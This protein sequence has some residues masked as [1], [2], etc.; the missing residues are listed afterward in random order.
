MFDTIVKLIADSLLNC[1]NGPVGIP[2]ARVY[3]S[4]IEFTFFVAL[5]GSTL[6]SLATVC[7]GILHVI[8]VSFY[9]TQRYRRAFIVYL[10]GT[11]PFVSTLSL[12]AMYMPRVW[13]LSHLLGF[14]Y[15]SIALWVIICLLMNIF[16]GRQKMVRKIKSGC[17]RISVQ[18][19]PLC[20]VFPCLPKLELEQGRI[21]FCEMMVFQAPC[22]RL[23]FT[24][25]SLILY[26][27]YQDGAIIALKILDFISLPSLL[28]GIYGTHILVT[29]VS[30]LDELIPYRYIVVFRLLDFYFMFYGLQQPIFDF[31]ARAGIFGCGTT[32]PSLE[33]AFFWKN[34]VLVIESF[35]VS[36]IS[37]VLLKPSRSAF[38]DKYPSSRSVAS[39]VVTCEY[40]T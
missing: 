30:N 36:L 32:L 4:R 3:L 39:S 23:I 31:L 27:E 12:I 40:S 17:S 6:I 35:F 9:V 37:T 8:Y 14:L 5:L 7:L 19:P 33:T 10:A 11:A 29:T 21:R 24:V 26:F 25:L 38:F 34:F 15:F 28:I 1:T 18:T 13:F 16:E 20:C 2:T 22:I